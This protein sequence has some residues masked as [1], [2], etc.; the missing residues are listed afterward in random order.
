MQW[1]DYAIILSVWPHGE[2]GVIASVLSENHGVW[3][4]FVY[5]GMSRQNAPCLERGTLVHCH[6]QGNSETQL[7]RFSFEM[8]NPYASHFMI[9]RLKLQAMQSLCALCHGALPNKEPQSALYQTSILL[10]DYMSAEEDA[11]LWLQHYIRWEVIFLAQIGF[12]LNLEEC[13]ETKSTQNLTHVSPKSGH[14]VCAQSA[15]PYHD[16]LLV[17][18]WFLNR[19]LREEGA[20]ALTHTDIQNGLKLTRFFLER[21][22]FQQHSQGMPQERYDLET[23]FQSVD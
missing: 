5:G 8:E 16:R 3:S 7:G 23:V 1:S 21:R 6:W 18:P 11:L 4:G 19:I 13:A 9:N 22:A 12:A 2:N 14:A 17:L 10:F 15:A 20:H